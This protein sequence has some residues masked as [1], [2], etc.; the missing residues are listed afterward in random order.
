MT[1]DTPMIP[2]TF[3]TLLDAVIIVDSW[4]GVLAPVM[5]DP[6]V[7]RVRSQIAVA[8]QECDGFRSSSLPS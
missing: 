2:T 1:A 5:K 6:Q 8:D 4:S 3:L 7:K